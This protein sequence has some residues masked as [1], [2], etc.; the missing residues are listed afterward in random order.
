MRGAVVAALALSISLCGHAFGGSRCFYDQYVFEGSPQT[1]GSPSIEV[2]GYSSFRGISLASRPDD[3]KRIA[4]S[5]GF[6]VGINYFIGEASA[7]TVEFCKG[8]KIVGRA[9]FDRDGQ[10]LR[11]AL[12][13]RFFSDSPIFVRD[14]ADGLFERYQVETS[15]VDDDVCFQDVTCFKGLSKY[16]EQFLIMRFGTEAELYVRR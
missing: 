12:K 15:K 10:M 8:G 14:L 2:S 4:H 9:D 7:S 6:H 5:L 3:V 13:D 1:S 11:L 16:G